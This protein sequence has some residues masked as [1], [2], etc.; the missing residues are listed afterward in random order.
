MSYAQPECA[1]SQATTSPT[2]VGRQTGPRKG[3]C[4][5]GT[6]SAEPRNQLH[7]EVKDSEQ[8]RTQVPRAILRP[9]SQPARQPP[10]LLT[11][12]PY[13]S[14]GHMLQGHFQ[15]D[16]G[17][18]GTLKES[19]LWPTHAW[20]CP[21]ATGQRMKSRVEKSLEG[22]VRSQVWASSASDSP[23][24]SSRAV[25]PVARGASVQRLVRSHP[26]I[27][28]ALRVSLPPPL[29]HRSTGLD[30][31]PALASPSSMVSPQLRPEQSPHNTPLL[32]L[33]TRPP[34]SWVSEASRHG[35]LAQWAG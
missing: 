5:R 14:T 9:A 23:T 26:E 24:W 31:P 1:S 29:Q 4:S 35:T 30:L 32:S 8:E 34:S 12:W 33:P 19:R 10:H 6:P 18:G 11:R 22:S 25:Q 28:T 20:P 17:A 2:R 21:M 13:G 27:P 15:R 3:P 16:T 7:P